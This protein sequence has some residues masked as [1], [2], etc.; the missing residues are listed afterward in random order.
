[1]KR[2]RKFLP[3]YMPLPNEIIG[4]ILSYCQTPKDYLAQSLVNHQWSIEARRIK[5][6]MKT[7]FARKVLLLDQRSIIWNFDIRSSVIGHGAHTHRH[8]LEECVQNYHR[9]GG[10]GASV[11]YLQRY[12]HEGTLH[13]L[14]I[15]REIN[16]IW[17]EHYNARE[18][19]RTNQG[20]AH[21]YQ[22]LTAIDSMRE[23]GKH[24]LLPIN[25]VFPTDCDSLGK[26]LLQYQWNFGTLEDGKQIE[27][28]L[29]DIEERSDLTGLFDFIDH[30]DLRS[31]LKNNNY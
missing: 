23:H 29:P 18:G 17:Y 26:I 15:I 31:L 30:V 7:R 4:L 12:W 5:S 16:Q 25:A 13:G 11:Y 21:P 6:R 10:P 24:L 14:E 27:R 19:E 1:M 3:E 28:K 9:V 2:R 8:G 20:I 22:G